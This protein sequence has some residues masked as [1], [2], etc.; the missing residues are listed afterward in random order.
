MPLTLRREQTVWEGQR[1]KCSW[2]VRTRLLQEEGK[3]EEQREEERKKE[4]KEKKRMEKVC[5]SAT[6][7]DTVVGR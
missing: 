5:Y 7:I 1:M 3:T 2:A 6:L 4:E